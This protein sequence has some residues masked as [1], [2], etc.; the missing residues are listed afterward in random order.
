MFQGYSGFSSS[1][2]GEKPECPLDVP[3]S[4]PGPFHAVRSREQ[5][6]PGWAGAPR[7]DGRGRGRPPKSAAE[8][9][10]QSMLKRPGGRTWKGEVKKL[11]RWRLFPCLAGVGML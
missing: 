9:E 6:K 8:Q 1:N 4:S 7:S 2:E 5:G 11:P 10:E 3:L